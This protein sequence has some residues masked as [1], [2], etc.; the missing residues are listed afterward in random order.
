MESNRSVTY[1]DVFHNGTWIRLWMGQT[2]SQL[3]DFVSRVAF[4]LLIYEITRSAVSLGFG[5]AIETLPIIVIGPIAG[6]LAD[7]MNRRTLLLIADVVRFFCAL[8]FF[9]STSLWQLYVLILAAATMQAVFVSTYSAVIPQI[10]EKQFVKSISL[11]YMGYNTMQVI[12]PAVAAALIG[13]AHGPRPVFLFDAATFALGVLM[14]STIRVGNLEN[15]GA[16]KH[17]FT[18]LR[19][20]TR[21]I[22]QHPLVRYVIVYYCIIA[23]SMSAATVATVIYIKTASGLPPTTSDQFYGLTGAV[24]AGGLAFGSWLIGLFDERLPKRF[25]ILFGPLLTGAAYLFFLLRPAP[26]V[27]LLIFL[28]VSIGNAS[29]QV[30]VLSF[31]AKTVPNDLRGRVYSFLNSATS[32]ASLIAFSAFAILA[33][34]LFPG[35]V[36]ALAGGVL[37]VGIP[38]CTVALRGNRTLRKYEEENKQEA[39][40]SAKDPLGTE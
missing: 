23:I 30:T 38:L 16:R 31:L 13:L 5:F 15:S 21:F 9:F 29:S 20:G 27:I 14:T 40:A 8:G 32:V 1:R 26:P 35:I 28:A 24:L 12:G 17:F 18:D 10:T 19:S 25:L 36:L 34:L 2:V 33:T 11:S 3:G 39:E 6:A 22:G 4:P 37:L 7:R